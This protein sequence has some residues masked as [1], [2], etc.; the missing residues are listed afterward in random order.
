M[1]LDKGFTE[2]EQHIPRPYEFPFR[3]LP[4]LYSDHSNLWSF[5]F[6]ICPLEISLVNVGIILFDL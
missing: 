3:A 2:K 5:K 4:P 1:V 6:Y